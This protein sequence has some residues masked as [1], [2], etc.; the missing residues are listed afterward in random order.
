M[1]ESIIF[2]GE[3]LQE[4]RAAAETCALVLQRFP[5]I[6]KKTKRYGHFRKFLC[7]YL[8]LQAL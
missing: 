1:H 8:Y 2:E 7:R 3:N 5:E 4:K 6:Q